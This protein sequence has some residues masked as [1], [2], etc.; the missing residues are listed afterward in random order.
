MLVKLSART[1]IV[2]TAHD[3]YIFPKPCSYIKQ[4]L[5]IKPSST[6]MWPIWLSIAKVLNTYAEVT[7]A[8]ILF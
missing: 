7:E 5:C 4:V 3:F 2:H 6:C 8:W 1:I